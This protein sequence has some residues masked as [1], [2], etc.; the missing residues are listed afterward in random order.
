M[1][2]PCF[3]HTEEFSILREK[4]SNSCPLINCLFFHINDSFVDEF[5][6]TKTEVPLQ[7]DVIR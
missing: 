6:T 3:S 5:I 2:L 1:A 7:L 4:T